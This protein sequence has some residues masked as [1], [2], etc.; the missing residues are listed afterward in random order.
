MDV[1]F[2][3][4]IPISTLLISL[5]VKPVFYD[6]GKVPVQL[7]NHP[8]NLPQV[9]GNVGVLQGLPEDRRGHLLLSFGIHGLEELFDGLVLSV[10]EFLKD[11][12]G[13]QVP[14][15]GVE[16]GVADFHTGSEFCQLLH[17]GFAH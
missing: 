14:G 15:D 6:G 3:P 11:L 10:Q 9:Q 2:S 17:E 1:T 4:N 8:L 7:P 12:E 5:S 13:G 16:D